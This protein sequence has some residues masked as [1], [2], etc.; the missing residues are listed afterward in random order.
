MTV[1]NVSMITTIYL[2]VGK[3]VNISVFFSG[4]M[5]NE[6][7][8]GTNKLSDNRFAVN[9]I[10][11]SRA[12]IRSQMNPEKSVVITCHSHHRPTGQ[13]LNVKSLTMVLFQ[14]CPR[15]FP[16]HGHSTGKALKNCKET[17]YNQPTCMSIIETMHVPNHSCVQTSNFVLKCLGEG[18]GSG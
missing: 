16:H 8:H 10:C 18:W 17:C 1:K 7:E 6:S 4:F 12:P 5:G 13:N 15:D 11:L 2:L 3:I 14:V 9:A